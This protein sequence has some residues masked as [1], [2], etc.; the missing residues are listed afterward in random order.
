MKGHR[1]ICNKRVRVG[2]ICSFDRGTGPCGVH[3]TRKPNK[4]PRHDYLCYTHFIVPFIGV[5]PIGSPRPR[6]NFFGSR[7]CK[8]SL[9]SRTSFR[10]SLVKNKCMYAPGGEDRYGERKKEVL[11]VDCTLDEHAIILNCVER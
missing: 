4:F 8:C 9:V 6:S 5:P 2:T 10:V 11:Y 1:A 7:K 3:A